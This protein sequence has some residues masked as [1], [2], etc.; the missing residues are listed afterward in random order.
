MSLRAIIEVIVHVE[1]FRNIDLY[2]QGLYYLNF[3][4]SHSARGYK[5]PAS[6]YNFHSFEESPVFKD[7]YKV[8]SA[9]IEDTNFRSRCFLIKYSDEEVEMNDIGI[10][11]TEIEL[12]PQYEE[13]VLIVDVD[14]MFYDLDGRID[15]DKIKSTIRNPP[16]FQSVSSAQLSITGSLQGIN[17]FYPIIF[18]ENHFCVANSA[19]HVLLIDFRFR[20]NPL[21][22]P[23]EEFLKKKSEVLSDAEI[24]LPMTLS[25]YM[26]KNTTEL[27]NEQ[28]DRVHDT[29][30]NQLIMA[31]EKNRKLMEEWISFHVPPKLREILPQIP[32]PLSQ[33]EDNSEMSTNASMSSL[34]REPFSEREQRREPNLVAEQI[35]REIQEFAGYMY[36]LG[37]QF[38]ELIKAAPKPICIMLQNQYNQKMKD[39]WGESIFREVKKVHEYALTTDTKIGESHRA[40]ARTLRKTPYY[41][42]LE[43]LPVMKEKFFPP[44]DWHPIMFQDVYTKFSEELGQDETD[45]WDPSWLTPMLDPR[46]LKKGLHLIVLHHGFQGNSFDVRSIRNQIA[47]YRP[48]CVLMCAHMN[49]GETEGDINEMGERL[50]REVLGYIEEWCPGQSLQKVSFIGHSL[51]GVIIRRALPYLISIAEKMHFFLTLSSPHLGYMYNSSKLVDAGL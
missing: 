23:E 35:L 28:I 32:Q 34:W 31:H 50:A 20:P 30:I 16:E 25:D 38:V 14:L 22:S 47:L 26:F 5:F 12:S 39:R 37:I 45:P 36:Y 21:L 2:Q 18:D 40:L 51:G 46:A 44:S 10:F 24:D 19:F 33:R 48:D 6:P 7:H 43:P 9:G 11:R 41:K 4:L 3:K 13:L 15:D 49:E 29:Y 1:S 8:F 27:N 17:A 42:N